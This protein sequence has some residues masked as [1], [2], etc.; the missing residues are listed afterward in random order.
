VYGASYSE[1]DYQEEEMDSGLGKYTNGHS[2]YASL[3]M[4]EETS[5]P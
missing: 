1:W 3:N 2:S 5:Q 4:P